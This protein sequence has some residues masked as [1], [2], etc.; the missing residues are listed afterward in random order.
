MQ[1]LHAPRVDH[2]IV[3][4]PEIDVRQLLSHNALNFAIKLLTLLLVCR[5]APF[6]NQFVHSGFE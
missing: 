5:S 6:I 4:I 3:K 1:I 2:N